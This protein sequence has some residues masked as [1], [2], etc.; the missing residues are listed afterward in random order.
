[1]RPLYEAMWATALVEDG[2]YRPAA[3]TLAAYLCLQLAQHLD[4]QGKRAL[5]EAALAETDWDAVIE[6]AA[7]C[8][9]RDVA[10]EVRHAIEVGSTATLDVLA[11]TYGAQKAR[12]T[13]FVRQ[14]MPIALRSARPS[15]PRR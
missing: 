1:M 4:H 6:L 9:M 11:L 8:G 3:S 2:R 12:A 7:R 10:G 15:E 13:R 5:F 14:I